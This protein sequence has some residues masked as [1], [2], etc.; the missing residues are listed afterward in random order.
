MPK[1]LLLLL[2]DA[3]SAAGASSA[4][5]GGMPLMLVASVVVSGV[6]VET[7]PWG[8]WGSVADIVLLQDL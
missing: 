2:V 3:A 8:L 5:A 7:S 1:F 4:G 6:P